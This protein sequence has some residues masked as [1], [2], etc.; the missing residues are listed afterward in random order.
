MPGLTGLLLEH[1]ASLKLKATGEL[2]GGGGGGSHG[3]AILGFGGIAYGCANGG[4]PG[5][6][7]DDAQF[8]CVTD[9]PSGGLGGAAG[10]AV[11]LNGFSLNIIEN[12]GS[13]LGDVS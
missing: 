5:E 1:N 9:W 10:K 3:A 7:G 2:H 8:A 11:D 6:K 13:L 12:D 4:G